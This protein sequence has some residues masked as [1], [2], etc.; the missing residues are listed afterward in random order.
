MARSSKS[1]RS[2]VI[3]ATPT[4]WC[5]GWASPS[6]AKRWAMRTAERRGSGLGALELMGFG[7]YATAFA[8]RTTPS[9]RSVATLYPSYGLGTRESV[10]RLVRKGR[11][12]RKGNRQEHQNL[13]VGSTASRFEPTDRKSTRL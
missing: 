3:F 5:W 11:K 10:K 13:G 4:G 12:E 9:L 7:R 6:M 8:V 2:P 1:T